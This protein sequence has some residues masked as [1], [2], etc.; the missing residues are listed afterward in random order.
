MLY[1]FD[2]FV[3]SVFALKN[4]I[5]RLVKVNLMKVRRQFKNKNIK[6]QKPNSTEQ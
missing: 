2:A 3:I 5:K 6:P 4:I 1:K